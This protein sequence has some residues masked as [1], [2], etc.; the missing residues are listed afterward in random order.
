MDYFGIILVIADFGSDLTVGISLFETCHYVWAALSMFFTALP[1]I[2]VLLF[3]IIICIFPNIGDEV[4]SYVKNV[5]GLSYIDLIGLILCFP[6]YVC[7]LA[8]QGQ[9]LKNKEL[10]AKTLKGLQLLE[11]FSESVPQF[12]L[13]C[14]IRIHL[15]P[16][17]PILF[18][19]W[20]GEWIP[21]FDSRIFSIV[22]SFCA[23]LYGGA[24]IGTTNMGTKTLVWKS[25]LI[26]VYCLLIDLSLLYLTVTLFAYINGFLASFGVLILTWSVNSVF[27]SK[28]CKRYGSE[29]FLLANYILVAP[30]LMIFRGRGYFKTDL[31]A[32]FTFLNGLITYTMMA[33]LVFVNTAICMDQENNN[34]WNSTE[35]IYEVNCENVCE[36]SDNNL[37]CNVKPVLLEQLLPWNFVNVG[38]F[39]FSFLHAIFKILTDVFLVKYM[40]NLL[41]S[42]CK[43]HDQ[44]KN[45]FGHYLDN[46]RP[47]Q[48]IWSKSAPDQI[49]IIWSKNDLV[50]CYY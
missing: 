24:M 17:E 23:M 4:S 8:I 10:G 27:I 29:R 48:M 34:V 28:T 11:L 15:G 3:V 36:I 40:T 26:N 18:G 12:I 47:D 45:L 14:Y 13:T 31:E 39:A 49:K 38:L 20:I 19:I 30:L 6:I 41:P 2:L 42:E 37:N 33:L 22:T 46:F 50:Q 32:K 35:P 16:G 9:I 7:F 21:Q 44:R 43:L 1:S 5:S 25:Y